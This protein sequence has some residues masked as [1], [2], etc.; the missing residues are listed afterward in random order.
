MLAH[1][2][3]LQLSLRRACPSSHSPTRRGATPWAV[4]R[5]VLSR[6]SR[7]AGM[8]EACGALGPDREHTHTH[9][10]QQGTLQS[11]HRA[12]RGAELGRGCR[13][14][15]PS[16][17]RDPLAFLACRSRRALRP[18]L[19]PPRSPSTVLL[20]GSAMPCPDQHTQGRW[21]LGSP[22]R[23]PPQG[24]VTTARRSGP[25]DRRPAACGQQTPRRVTA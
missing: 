21:L 18:V 13:R 9:H 24:R 19:R 3:V 23:P 10:D 17:E 6:Q 8:S 4:L 1:P 25:L 7:G 15:C 5:G 22:G 11:P 20:C 12:Q 16:H 14:A 2:R